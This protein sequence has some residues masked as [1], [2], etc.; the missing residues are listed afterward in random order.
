VSDLS[1]R[2]IRLETP[3]RPRRILSGPV[4]YVVALV[5]G[6]LAVALLIVG[7]LGIVLLVAGLSSWLHPGD[8]AAAWARTLG[9]IGLIG[10]SAALAALLWLAVERAVGSGS[11]GE[12]GLRR[13]R[14]FVAAIG[15]LLALICLPFAAAIHAS[16]PA[17]WLG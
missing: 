3:S 17:P 12:S 6:A 16:A 7:V 4:P 8:V 15:I 5:V 14:K 1:D 11:G 2:E 10:G 9:G 13:A